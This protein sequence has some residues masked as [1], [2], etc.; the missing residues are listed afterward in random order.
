MHPVA[1]P[2]QPVI[3]MNR[4]T[5]LEHSEVP[6]T[7]VRELARC[8][9]F[10]WNPQAD[11]IKCGAHIRTIWGV[12]ADAAFDFA[13]FRKGVHP[14]DWPHVEGEI[15]RCLDPDGD[16]VYAIEYRVIS[17]D[18]GVERWVQVYG[19]A[20]FLDRKPVHFT[21]ALVE[22][23]ERKR[24]Q[25]RLAESEQRFRRFAENSND[26]LWIGDAGKEGFDYLSPAYERI[27]GERRDSFKPT[28][29][30]WA[31]TVHPD[32]RARALAWMALLHEGGEAKSLDYRIIRSDGA[33]RDIRDS[34]FP[35]RDP[36]GGVH[37]ISGIASDVTRTPSQQAYVVG[38]DLGSAG[39]LTSMLERVG[40]RVHHFPSS[41]S[42]MEIAP[43][44]RPGCVLLDASPA[45][46]STLSV[47]QA[48]RA[49]PGGMRSIVIG[50][51]AG[52]ITPAVEAMKCGASDYLGSDYLDETL[53]AAVASVMRGIQ[54]SAV[55]DHAAETAQGRIASLSAREHEVLAGLLA[56]GSNKTIARKLGISPRT[57][58]LHR[59]HLMDKVNA[60]GLQELIHVALAAG[61]KIDRRHAG[62]PH[63]A[64][65]AT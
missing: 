49:P 32:D 41:L 35:I 31:M 59:A 12:A 55:M 26:A 34:A 51:K 3:R 9:P 48:I 58:E 24:S 4:C 38:F 22:I 64:S 18:D 27:W 40:Y 57:V 56:G 17:I 53:L 47:L 2:P 33:V 63:P 20:V 8:W 1:R 29:T 46:A 6:E 14:E 39:R 65:D 52:G 30:H 25:E 23:T 44:L 37:C 45:I 7:V 5:H 10:S 16:A 28:F 60:H 54:E 42:F 36:K 19:G 62:A 15:A 50:P 61:L 13:T 43:V 21:G 11:T